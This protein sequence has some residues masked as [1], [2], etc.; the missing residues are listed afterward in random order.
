MIDLLIP[1]RSI[2]PHDSLEATVVDP[3]FPF[4]F[5]FNSMPYTVTKKCL[6]NAGDINSTTKLAATLGHQK[7]RLFGKLADRLKDS[8][9][10]CLMTQNRLGFQAVTWDGERIGI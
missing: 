8:M 3:I 5:S 9:S 1:D 4:Y 7:P 6:A 2:V 10:L